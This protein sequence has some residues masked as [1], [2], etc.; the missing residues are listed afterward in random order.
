M[1]EATTAEDRDAVFR[2]W[3]SVYVEEMGRYRGVADHDRR[4]LRDSE[5]ES[6]RILFAREDGVVVAAYRLCWGGDGFSERQIRQYSL[7]PFLDELPKESLVIGERTMVAASHRGGTVWTDLAMLAGPLCD[8]LGAYVS[9]GAC[10]PHLVAYYAQFNNQPYAMRQFVSEESGYL[11]P[12]IS[13]AHG[14]EP[15]GEPVPACIERVIRGES[16]VRNG[17]VI[18]ADA[19]AAELHDAL[20]SLSGQPSLL[21]GLGK[22]DVERCCVHSSLITCAAGD[23]ILRRGGAAR[24]PFMLVFGTLEVVTDR[25]RFVLRPGELFGE[26]GW[27]AD[28]NRHADVFATEEGSRVLALSVGTLRKLEHTAP[29][30]ALKISSNATTM[31]WSRLRDADR[32]TG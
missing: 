29:A 7:Q 5:D 15:F 22:D 12:L 27:L 16:S 31:L 8:D 1:A 26:S 19:Y 28:D 23:Q 3:Y 21:S 24:N 32:L 14:V 30:L 13:F 9:F 11:I 2:F 10:E 17:D 25:S 6:S 20:A 4:Q 18:G